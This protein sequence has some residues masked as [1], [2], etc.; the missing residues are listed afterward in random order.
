VPTNSEKST[1]NE[2]YFF[3][4]FQAHLIFLFFTKI[5]LDLKL[6]TIPTINKW[7]I[8]WKVNKVWYKR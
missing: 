5:F 1:E 7:T 6:T 2:L 4:V 3:H 8:K